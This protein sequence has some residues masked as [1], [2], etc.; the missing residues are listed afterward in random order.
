MEL[1]QELDSPAERAEAVHRM[2][3]HYLHSAYAANLMTGPHQLTELEPAPPGVIPEPCRDVAAAYR[4]LTTEYRVLLMGIGQAIESG[5]ARIAWQLAVTLYNFQH[6]N[7]LLRDWAFASQ[8]ALTAAD[9]AGDGLGRVRARRSLAG[10]YFMFG[11]GQM[12]LKLLHETQALIDELGLPAESAFIS[13]GIAETL[14][15]GLPNLPQDNMAAM[16]YFRLAITQY[17]EIGHVQGVAY[18]MEGLAKCHAL[19]GEYA[20]AVGL[21]NDALELHRS[22]SDSVG[23]GYV[24]VRLADIDLRM[25]NLDNAVTR[26]DQAIAL[27]V[28]GRHRFMTIEDLELLGDVRLARD[29]PDAARAA[30][31][32]ALD[33]C[34]E[35]GATAKITTLQSRLAQLPT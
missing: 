5:H 8:A 4:W 19:Q 34:V 32:Q 30:W 26:L 7:G 31:T 20:E 23:E 22:I 15:E 18:C 35:F 28:R 29:E 25:G 14:G 1:S 6:H 13:R 17:R 24:F 33:L 9:E 27:H 12:A 11:D 2:L 16:R 3:A 10:A 21:L